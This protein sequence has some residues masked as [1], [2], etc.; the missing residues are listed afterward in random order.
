MLSFMKTYF[1]PSIFSL[2]YSPSP[3][4]GT[5]M[6]EYLTGATTDFPLVPMLGQDHH[7][8]QG[9][10]VVNGTAIEYPSLLGG[11]DGC[12]NT[13]FVFDTNYPKPCAQI[14]G[15]HSVSNF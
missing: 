1:Y 9:F 4:T 15:V 5:N 8:S 11:V 7:C 14:L 6:V 13:F 12:F 3:K 10:F 2:F